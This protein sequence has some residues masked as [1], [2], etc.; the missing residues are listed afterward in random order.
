MPRDENPVVNALRV[1]VSLTLGGLGMGTL[2]YAILNP[3]EE[4][5]REINAP[6]RSKMSE[7]T[8]NQEVF[9]NWSGT[10]EVKPL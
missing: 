6:M 4:W 7:V 1:T 3:D 2:L 8:E 5:E 10:H 9:T